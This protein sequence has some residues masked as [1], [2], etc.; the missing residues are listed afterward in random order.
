MRATQNALMHP[1]S[2]RGCKD[3]RSTSRTPESS[4]HMPPSCIHPSLPSSLPSFSCFLCPD[5]EMLENRSPE[6]RFILLLKYDWK[7]S[8]INHIGFGKRTINCTKCSCCRRHRRSTAT[9]LYSLFASELSC[10]ASS[11]FSS[12]TR[13]QSVLSEEAREREREG[14][15]VLRH[16]GW[17]Q[18]CESKKRNETK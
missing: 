11:C 14:E 7:A 4:S 15:K 3:S 8:Q 5:A 16:G 1:A 10:F 17:R 6:I 9:L 13:V 18:G 12:L 2:D